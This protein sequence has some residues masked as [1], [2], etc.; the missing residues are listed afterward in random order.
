MEEIDKEKL[1]GFSLNE[2]SKSLMTPDQHSLLGAEDAT[3]IGMLHGQNH[4][5]MG[6][7]YL[8]EAILDE[9]RRGNTV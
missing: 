7:A 6:I 9:L 8:L 5:L 3:I 1:A 2:L 4:G